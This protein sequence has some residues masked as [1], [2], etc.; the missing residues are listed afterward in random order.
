M[1]SRR[2]FLG[3]VAAGFAAGT[4]ADPARLD[5]SLLPAAEP[6]AGSRKKLA[7]VTTV[8]NY[9]SHAWHMAER[10]LHGYPIGGK[11][12]HPPF[13][14]VAAYVDQKPEGDLSRS[15]ADE[16]GFTIYPSIA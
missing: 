5:P 12:H 6:A 9:R 16:F 4:L 1:L 3:T 7:V 10:F 8:W 15:R 14:V 11:W 2:R 13:E